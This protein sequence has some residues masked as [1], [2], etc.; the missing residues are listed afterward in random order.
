MSYFRREVTIRFKNGDAADMVSE[1]DVNAEQAVIRVIHQ[2]FPDH[3]ILG[4]SQPPTPT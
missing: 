2:T 4:R 1:A 3:A